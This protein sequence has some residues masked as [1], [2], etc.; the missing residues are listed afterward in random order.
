MQA[1]QTRGFHRGCGKS[2][3]EGTKR[4]FTFQRMAFP[5]LLFVFLV[6]SGLALNYRFRTM[7]VVVRFKIVNELL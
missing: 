1:S 5:Q 4:G 6:L 7:Y 3:S 2:F